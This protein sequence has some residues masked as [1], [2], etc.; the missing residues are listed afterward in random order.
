MQFIK[1]LYTLVKQ[2]TKPSTLNVGIVPI[3]SFVNGNTVLSKDTT[4]DE[5]EDGD[6]VSEQKH[7][8]TLSIEVPKPRSKHL[9]DL[10]AAKKNAGGRHF[11][12][13]KDYS[14]AKIKSADRKNV[15]D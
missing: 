4:D 11:D 13:K 7:E 6:A 10:M 2:S 14:R 5:N 12:Q 15:D 1:E 8:N 3:A 9:N